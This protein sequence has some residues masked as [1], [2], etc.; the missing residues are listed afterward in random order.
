MF[1]LYTPW[2]RQIKV[3]NKKTRKRCQICSKLTDNKDTNDANDVVPVSLLLTLNIFT[4]CSSVSIINF[5][6]VVV[7]WE[8]CF[9]CSGIRLCTAK[10]I[11]FY[12]ITSIQKIAEG[13]FYPK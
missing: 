8:N 3:S 6:H 11:S 4:P 2:K 12:W 10:P 1:P 9:T 5:E 7:S 13:D